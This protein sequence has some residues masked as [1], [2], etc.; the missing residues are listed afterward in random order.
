[1]TS[2]TEVQSKLNTVV[3]IQHIFQK[4][5]PHTLKQD[6]MIQII[7]MTVNTS[8][9]YVWCTIFIDISIGVDQFRSHTNEKCFVSLTK[10]KSGRKGRKIF[11]IPQNLFKQYEKNTLQGC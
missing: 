10:T 2:K 9:Q 6:P 7:A 8:A 5:I 11:N 3:N 1:M 4:M